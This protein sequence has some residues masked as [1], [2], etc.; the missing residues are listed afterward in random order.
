[1][2]MEP[3]FSKQRAGFLFETTDFQQRREVLLARFYQVL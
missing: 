2:A 1:M 3:R